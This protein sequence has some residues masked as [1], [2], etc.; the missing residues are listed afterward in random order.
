MESGGG[1]GITAEGFV[2]L[3]MLIAEGEAVHGALGGG[4]DANGTE[5]GI[6]DHY[7]K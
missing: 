2:V 7:E 3:I 5:E 6:G 1:A 4:H